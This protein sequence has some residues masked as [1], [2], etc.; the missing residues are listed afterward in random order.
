MQSARDVI[1]VIPV[2][3]EA[4]SAAERISLNQLL[5]TLDTHSM[6]LVCPAHLNAHE[7]QQCFNLRNVKVDIQRFDSEYFGSIAGY[8]RLLLS[9]T[10]YERFGHWKFLLI[11]QLDCLVLKD[12]LDKWVR[13]DYDYIGSPWV[14]TEPLRFYESLNYSR[15]PGLGWLKR[16]FDYNQGKMVTVGNGGFSLRKVKRFQQVSRLLS[17]FFRKHLKG[18]VNEDYIWSI[19]VPK[20]F[21]KFKVPSAT[22]ASKFALE[23]VSVAVNLDAMESLPMAVH[24]WE[25]YYPDWWQSLLTKYGK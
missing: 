6:A 9:Q 22:M 20:Y 4:L 5:H 11:H 13:A 10:F 8:N 24:A 25:K 19:L 16:R 17:L 2:Y 7:Y 23:K 12:D 1:I 3:K 18:Q 14:D 15:W 21:P